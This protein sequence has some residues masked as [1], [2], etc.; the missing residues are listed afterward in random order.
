MLAV[1]ILQRMLLLVAEAVQRNQPQVDLHQMQRNLYHDNFDCV[2]P[3]AGAGDEVCIVP[4]NNFR[5]NAPIV[6]TQIGT[7]TV[8]TTKIY[9]ILGINP[10]ANVIYTVNTSRQSNTVQCIRTILNMLSIGFKQQEI[11]T[12]PNIRDIHISTHNKTGALAF[13]KQKGATLTPNTRRFNN[14][15]SCQEPGAH[16]VFIVTQAN[17][18]DQEAGWIN[19]PDSKPYVVYMLI[20]ARKQIIIPFS[21]TNNN[22]HLGWLIQHQEYVKHRNN[23]RKTFNEFMRANMNQK[24]CPVQGL[25]WAADNVI[26]NLLLL[27]RYTITKSPAARTS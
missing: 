1:H 9:R 3:L 21:Y 13:L 27:D 17:P 14:L 19:I 7:L 26:H 4:N 5:H 15:L 23:I 22:I 6:N 11:D 20:I 25:Q 2:D 18:H 12:I 16:M 10:I 24:F 8:D